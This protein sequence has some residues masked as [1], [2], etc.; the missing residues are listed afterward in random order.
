MNENKT[1]K[2]AL[3]AGRYFKYAIGEIILVVIGILIA[4]SINKW[5]E[6]RKENLFEKKVLSEILMD[7]EE[8]LKEMK[9]A[10]D[11]INDTQKSSYALLAHLNDR[12]PYH[13]SLD[14]HF[15][16]QFGLWSLSPN[17]TS[18]EMAKTE[19][20]HI[21]K[22]DSIRI[23]ASKVNEYLFDYIRVLESRFQDYKTNIVLSYTLP[24]FDSYNFKKMKPRNYETLIENATYLG[25]IK[26]LSVMRAR[27]LRVIKIRYELL[28]KLNEM[29]KIELELE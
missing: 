21:I 14:F 9:N 29:I 10:L 28:T 18:F 1:G 24:L 23:L 20:L 19:G 3:P 25:I 16:K 2:P 27:Y 17:T 11:S 8:D 4:L 6:E 7:T 5:N 26:T 22:N 13:D 12:K 15:A